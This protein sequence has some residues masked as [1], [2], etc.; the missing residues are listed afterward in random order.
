[1]VQKVKAGI[2]VELISKYPWTKSRSIG[3]FVADGKIA[4]GFL[5]GGDWKQNQVEGQGHCASLLSYDKG[6][7]DFSTEPS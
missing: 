4:G 5:G 6:L 1:M 2:L 3:Q 7:R